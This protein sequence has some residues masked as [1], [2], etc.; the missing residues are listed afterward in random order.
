MIKVGV[1]HGWSN[2]K[3]LIAIQDRQNLPSFGDILYTIDAMD[4]GSRYLLMEVTGFHGEAPHSSTYVDL[5]SEIARLDVIM[6]VNAR[7]FIEI[8]KRKDGKV[9]LQRASRP[10]QIGNTVYIT[11]KGDVDSEEIMKYISEYTYKASKP[12]SRGIGVVVLRAG[13]AHNEIVARE[14]YFY[15]AQFNVDLP[16][17]LKKHVLVVGQTGSGKTSGIQGILLKYALDS[18]EPIGWLVID[19]HGEYTPPEGYV[20]DK[21]IGYL[22]DAIRSN[23]DLTGKTRIVTYRLVKNA[24]TTHKIA[25]VASVFDVLYTPISASSITLHDFFGLEHISMDVASMVEEFVQLIM[26]IIKKYQANVQ[27]DKRSKSRPVDPAR[28]ASI[29]WAKDDPEYANGNML[30]MIPLIVDNFIRYEGVGA[31]SEEKRGIHKELV[32]RGIDAR[33]SRMLRR[34]ILSIMGWRIKTH[35]GKEGY[36]IAVIDDTNSVVKVSESLKDPNEL[37]CLLQAL[38]IGIGSSASDRYPWINMCRDTENIVLKDSSGVD[39]SQVVNLIDEGNIV[40]FDV[41]QLDNVMAD[42]AVLTLVRKIFEKRLEAGVESSKLKPVISI[43]SEE[44]PL[45]LGSEH[46]RSPF[47]PFA[48][49]AREGRKFGIGLVAITQMASLIERQ[50]LGNFNTMITMRTRSSSDINL[51]RDIGIPVENLPFLGDRECFIYT[52]ELPI[53]EPIPVYIPAWFDEI[54]VEEVK[55]RRSKM[56]T[57]VTKVPEALLKVAD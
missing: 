8:V 6:L 49:I 11:K 40:I 31:R 32:E 19:R 13:Q 34:M 20:E 28:I 57:Q 54:Y 7:L 21:F 35:V 16:D 45:Y 3:V 29:F 48:R 1:V 47:N 44:A 17:M 41:S 18:S 23:P 2:D 14:K 27:D 50:I 56:R 43:V 38:K 10:P 52:P 37:A 51:M 9:I 30:A 12:G 4:N 26:D 53:K 15:N 55:K 39:F 5:R 24:N 22:V 25:T 33:S 46:V 36:S 42:L